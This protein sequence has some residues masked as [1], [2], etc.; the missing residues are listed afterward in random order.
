VKRRERATAAAVGLLAAGYN[1]AVNRVLPPRTH[2]PANLAFAA[3]V[4]GL[5]RAA[6][7]VS[8]S[9]LG[10]GRAEARSGFRIG[11]KA[12][13][14]SAAL[15]AAAAA[16]PGTRRF[17]ADERIL[18]SSRGAA[19]YEMCVRIPLATALPEEVVFRG[20]LLSVLSR[21]HTTATAIA[22]TST[23]FGLW[24]VLP[25]LDTMRTNPI[26][27]VLPEGWLGYSAAAGAAI[28]STAATGALFAL[29]RNRSGSVVAPVLTHTAINATAYIGGRL[30][31]RHRPGQP[32]R[33]EGCRHDRHREQSAWATDSVGKRRARRNSWHQ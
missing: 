17:F 21:S 19:V 27:D 33:G 9:D 20:V 28:P 24:H 8:W 7:R 2:V 29:L 31:R 15:V 26:K 32:I 25:T 23:L 11:S 4:C 30:S 6:A 18:R 1:V 14:A 12:S 5:G 13:L 16:A 10:L 3:A 22:W